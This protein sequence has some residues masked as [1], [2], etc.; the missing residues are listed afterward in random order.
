MTG[1]TVRF[2][3]A[4]AFAMLLG[5]SA[6]PAHAQAPETTLARSASVLEQIWSWLAGLVTAGE[7]GCTV[8]PNGCTERE[9]VEQDHGCTVDPNGSGNCA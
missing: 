7:H 4:A 3:A 5:V 2:A 6:V 8:D 1:K 9:V